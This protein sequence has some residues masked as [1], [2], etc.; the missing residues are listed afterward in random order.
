MRSARSFFVLALITAA[1][2]PSLA[3]SIRDDATGGDC[4]SI[5]VWNAATKTCV[6]GAAAA[7]SSMAILDDNITLDGNGTTLYGGT[8]P[9][10]GITV[11]GRS[12]VTIQNINVV[13]W[14]SGIVFVGGSNNTVRNSRSEGSAA[15][16]GILLSACSNS[17]L[18]GNII[19][20]NRGDGI[21]LEN[22]SSENT[23][24]NNTISD[25]FNNVVVVAGSNDNQIYNNNLVQ[26]PGG[27]GGQQ[28]IVAGTS[29]NLF[30]LPAP[31]GGN[32]WSSWTSPNDNGDTFVDLP[33]TIIPDMVQDLLPWTTADG[34]LVAPPDPDTD[35]DGVPNADDN[36]PDLQNPEQTDTDLD[37]HGDACDAD[38]DNDG[39][40]DA[41]DDCPFLS[42][43]GQIDLDGDGLGDPCDEDLDGDGHLNA[44]DNC[45]ASPNAYQDDTD[46]DL[47]GDACDADDDNDGICDTDQP[48]GVCTA[49]PDNC[50]TVP[51][52]AQ[53]D[54]DGDGI[55][56]ACDADLDGDGIAN[57]ADNCSTTP[58]AAQDDTDQDQ[59]GDA[60]DADDDG[61]G[62]LDTADN[63]PLV[64]NPGQSDLDGDG[65]GDACDA[66][67]DGD[68]AGN[69]G[70]NCP[71]IANSGQA[72][73]DGDGAGDACDPDIDG[74]GVPNGTDLCA[75]TASGATVLPDNGCSI[76]QLV[77]CGGP[78]GTNQPWK[79]HGQYTSSV[80]RAAGQFVSLGLMTPAEKDALVAA[81][82]SSGCGR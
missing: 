2:S 24:R 31:V 77:P 61:D 71:E 62:L 13:A 60:C 17:T 42:N 18:E 64:A 69:A 80:A 51:N 40:T 63:C 23:V 36:C 67:V 57:A 65:A 56:D 7:L 41:G 34:W 29:G 21:R 53:A 76:G 14:Q 15:G 9:F 78:R 43:P 47:A 75:G 16:V 26:S 10:T 66:D 25:N 45:P 52:P 1:A 19:Q 12:G 46:A 39:V 5:G 33:F 72:D 8:A 55:G 48:G 22:G 28:A 27:R 73:L 44:A 32:F 38:D 50:A 35:G 81:A 68:G 59:A 70:D 82:A 54:L 20:R 79:N 30:S 6:V 58:N 49:G 37:A 4:T 11:I 74:D 3:Q